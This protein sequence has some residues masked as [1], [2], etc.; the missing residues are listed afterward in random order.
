M[1]N[2]S[3]PV[4]YGAQSGGVACA[5][6]K[7]TE[8]EVSRGS[9][10][11]GQAQASVRVSGYFSLSL[12]SMHVSLVVQQTGETVRVRESQGQESC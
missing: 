5:R 1:S 8:G 6:E 12:C 3:V 10:A 9:S 11:R 4:H 2:Q 7:K